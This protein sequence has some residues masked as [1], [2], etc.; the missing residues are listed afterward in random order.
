MMIFNLLIAANDYN[1]GGQMT[2]QLLRFLANKHKSI[3]LAVAGI[4][5]QKVC[6]FF[7]Y[8]KPFCKKTQTFLL[9]LKLSMNL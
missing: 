3:D 9:V 2:E 1:F 7:L 4:F 6:R 5:L 8:L